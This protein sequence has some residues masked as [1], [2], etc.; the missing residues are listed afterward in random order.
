MYNKVRLRTWLSP[1][2]YRV[3]YQLTYIWHSLTVATVGRGRTIWVLATS[4]EV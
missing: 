3:N 2:I 1:G 4:D